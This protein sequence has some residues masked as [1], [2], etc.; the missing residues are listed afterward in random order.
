MG[1][2][3]VSSGYTNWY[4][5]K[6]IR[7]VKKTSKLRRHQSNCTS[8]SKM[9]AR[10]K[11]NSSRFTT[12]KCSCSLITAFT[13]PFTWSSNATQKSSEFFISPSRHIQKSEISTLR[14]IVADHQQVRPDYDPFRQHRPWIRTENKK[15][16]SCMSRRLHCL[17]L[18]PASQYYSS[19]QNCKEDKTKDAAGVGEAVKRNK[20]LQLQISFLPSFPR[21]WNLPPNNIMH[22]MKDSKHGHQCYPS[23]SQ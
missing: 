9:K 2:S 15:K 4:T 18:P 11:S 17:E 5:E 7:N 21:N 10:T 20:L 22:I 3:S 14:Q 23:A 19:V 12:L 8:S 13:L 6:Y 1:S 16:E